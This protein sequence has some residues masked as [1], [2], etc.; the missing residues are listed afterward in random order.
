MTIIENLLDNTGYEVDEVA[1]LED[2]LSILENSVS[3]AEMDDIE[4]E[5]SE[6]LNTKEP[7]EIAHDL[8][9]DFDL[10]CDHLFN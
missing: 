7:I 2:V 5:V 10:A 3:A 8:A 4:F 6:A 9:Y 1:I